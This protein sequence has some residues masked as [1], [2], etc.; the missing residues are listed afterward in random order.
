[1][2]VLVA[3]RALYTTPLVGLFHR[4]DQPLLQQVQQGFVAD[5]AKAQDWW[6]LAGAK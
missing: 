3:S 4:G 6:T 2:L 1:M 5:P